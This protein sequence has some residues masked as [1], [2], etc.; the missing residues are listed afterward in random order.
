MTSFLRDVYTAVPSSDCS[1]VSASS[2]RWCR[3]EESTGRLVGI[4]PTSSQRVTCA[5]AADN[6]RSTS[7]TWVI[8][9]PLKHYDI[10]SR[11][12]ITVVG[13]LTRMTV[14]AYSP[15]SINFVESPSFRMASVSETAKSTF[16]PVVLNVT[17]TT[18]STSKGY[19]LLARQ[20]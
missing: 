17:K 6:L 9:C 10:S 18:S 13:S 19:Q 15:S 16:F 2:T 4:S 14:D 5:S 8:P 20:N 12:V 1:S 3:S 11:S 7:T